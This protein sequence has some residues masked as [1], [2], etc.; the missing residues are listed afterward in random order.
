MSEREEV[1]FGKDV[2]EREPLCIVGRNGNR[3]SHHEK[4]YEKKL[5]VIL[6][7]D[8]EILLLG[9]YMKSMKTVNFKR[10]MHPYIHCIIFI[11]AKMWNQPKCLSMHELIKIMTCVHSG[12]LLKHK[13]ESF[14]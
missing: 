1:G 5:P 2:E 4:Q 9:V 10:P 11:I 7:Y 8:P 14:I 12:I 13:K 3:Y 6:L